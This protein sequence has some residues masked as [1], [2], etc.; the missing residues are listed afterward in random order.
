MIKLIKIK[1]RRLLESSYMPIWFIAHVL[2]FTWLSIRTILERFHRKSNWNINFDN[3]TVF[4][5]GSGSSVKGLSK[6]R[7]DYIASNGVS[8]GINFWFLHEFIP[9]YYTVELTPMVYDKVDY[10]NSRKDFL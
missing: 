1:L 8:I 10:I 9:D 4:I 7:F 6:D 2:Y 3:S 5:L